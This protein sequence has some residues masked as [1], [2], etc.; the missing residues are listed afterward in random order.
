MKA[1]TL[2]FLFLLVAM[3]SANAQNKPTPAAE[4][5]ETIVL[6]GVTAHIG[7]GTVV[8]NATIVLNKGKITSI[9]SE[10]PK[11]LDKKTAVQDLKGK[12]IYPG[13]IACAR[14]SA[15]GLR[16]AGRAA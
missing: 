4:Q 13:F 14:T 9:G 6:T 15:G 10:M 3:T 12:H 2:F 8:N 16:R 7:N 11:D 5:T 1:N